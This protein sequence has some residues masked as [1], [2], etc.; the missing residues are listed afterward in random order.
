[1]GAKLR[2]KYENL[3]NILFFLHLPAKSYHCN[4]PSSADIFNNTEKVKNALSYPYDAYKKV[5][6]YRVYPYDAYKN[7]KIPQV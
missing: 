7:I 6:I 4:S 1:M 5:K 2:E 3:Q